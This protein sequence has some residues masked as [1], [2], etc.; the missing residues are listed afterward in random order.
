MNN[1][2]VLTSA[3]TGLA[4]VVSL[5]ASA[6]GAPVFGPA[7]LDRMTGA[8]LQLA[9]ASLRSALGAYR[10]I[11]DR[12]IMDTMVKE[13][14]KPSADILSVL[15]AEMGEIPNLPKKQAPFEDVAYRFGKVAALAFLLNDPLRESDDPRVSAV[16]ED[17]RG[18]VER[19]LPLMPLAFDGYENPPMAGDA[20]GYFG[21]PGHAQRRV[22][23]REAVL[24]CY[25]PKGK[26]VTSESFDDRS[27]AFGVA[28]AM[29]SHAVSD[30]AKTWFQIWK[31][32]DGDISATPYYRP[33]K[34]S[35]ADAGAPPRSEEKS[36]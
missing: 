36:P 24:F 12:G 34:Q 31:A 20:H 3:V 28:Q 25:Y 21:L 6:P 13:S 19:K 16:R 30:A 26:Q 27:N 17:Y 11:L 14:R 5:S 8:T 35:A 2:R 7:A 22:R 4:V 33:K 9:P 29:A 23:Y 10:G 32:M 18:Y 15:Q 1:S